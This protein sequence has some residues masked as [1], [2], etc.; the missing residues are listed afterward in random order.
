MEST[1]TIQDCG[2]TEVDEAPKEATKLI[3]IPLTP[4][5]EGQIK[6]IL[7]RCEQFL[8][9]KYPHIADNQNP[10]KKFENF[11]FA[12]NHLAARYEIYYVNPNV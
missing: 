9:N 6:G 1:E 12:I 10:I 11:Y 5:L 3:N 8:K 7:Q 4:P 2:V